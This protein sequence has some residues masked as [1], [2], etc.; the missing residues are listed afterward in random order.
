MSRQ[1]VTFVR[2]W[3]DHARGSRIFKR[4]ETVNLP[5]E[6]ADDAINDGAAKAATGQADTG[7]STVDQGGPGER[8]TKPTPDAIQTKR[9][10][11]GAGKEAGSGPVVQ[12]TPAGQD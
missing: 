5:T 12:D 3:I 8:E 4:G 7:T 9:T 11:D 1:H 10:R 6:Q 2:N